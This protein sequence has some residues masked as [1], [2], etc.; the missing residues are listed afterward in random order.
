MMRPPLR[1]LYAITDNT[2]IAPSALLE[3]VEKVLMGGAT[4]IQYR[5]KTTDSTRRE[6]EAKA[7]HELCQD[8]NAPLIINDDIEL[9]T[10]VGAE[11]VHLGKHDIKYHKTR[12]LMGEG[13]IIGVSC[14]DQLNRA[15]KA[16]SV[17]ADYVA[18][19]S[20]FPSKTK[21][22][23]VRATTDLLREAR[24]LISIPIV[25]IG[26]ITPE[27]GKMLLDSGADL[28]AVIQG[29]FGEPNPEDAAKRYSM[30][31]EYM[32]PKG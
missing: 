6:Q 5:D 16:E 17:G 20:F 24:Q 29:L 32:T 31:F 4:V 15:R 23:T 28:L 3:M 13:A 22:N 1:G 27:N 11:G 2:L 7:L 25:A 8:H 12:E 21:P 9:A 18:F 19:G 14:Y 30:L 10:M 26:G